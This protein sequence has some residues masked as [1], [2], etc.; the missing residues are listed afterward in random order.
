MSRT[1]RVPEATS[2]SRP[3]P[4][5]GRTGYYTLLVS[6]D[7]VA[8]NRRLANATVSHLQAGNR[9]GRKCAQGRMACARPSN[10][11]SSLT[12]KIDPYRFL[13]R[14]I[15]GVRPGGLSMVGVGSRSPTGQA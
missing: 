10:L 14:V 8:G 5:A 6:T 2:L 12:T 13:N 15:R 9:G 11:N 4:R 1:G 3:R 7:H